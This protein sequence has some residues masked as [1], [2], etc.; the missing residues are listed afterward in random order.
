MRPTPI[1]PPL[2]LVTTD[3]PA[4]AEDDEPDDDT[5]GG[6]FDALRNEIHRVLAR[7]RGSATMT[8]LGGVLL[9]LDALATDYDGVPMPP[10]AER[11]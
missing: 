9:H 3:P 8:T 7:G 1:R 2:R 10:P 5:L 11:T 6:L 4:I